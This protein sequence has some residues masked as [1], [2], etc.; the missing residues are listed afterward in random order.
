MSQ[1]ISYKS[2]FEVKV[3]HHYFLNKG[4]QAWDAMSQLEKVRQEEKFDVREILDI[5]PTADCNKLLN[6][7]KCIFRNTSSGFIIGIKAFADVANAGKFKPLISLSDN[8]TFRFVVKLKDYNFLNYTALTLQNSRNKL[9]ALNN[10]I[11]NTSYHFPSL[12]SIP[13][14][15][16]IGKTYMPGDMLSDNS[17]NQS[18]LFTALVKT[19]VNPVGSDDWLTEDGN[20][21]TP[22]NYV[23]INDNYPVA[24]GFFTYTMT[25]KDSY[26][27]AKIK[28][29]SGFTINP[30]MEVLQGDFYKLQIDML[31]YPEGI[32]SIHIDS[33][34]PAYHD[35][36]TFY[37]LQSSDIP[38]ALVEVKV[39]SKQT[40]FDLTNQGDLLS[41]VFEIRF[42]NR[43]THWR[44]VGKFFNTP[45][46]PDNPLPLTRYGNIEV[47]KP[48]D[49]ENDEAI[50]L[51]NPSA[52]LI[53]AEA[54]INTNETKFY[55]EIHIN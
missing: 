49:L 6:A 45:F 43:R 51:P 53:K 19:T 38:F 1:S 5:T 46:I 40:A 50:M 48:P 4:E 3:R 12:S 52:S 26:P 29:A 24:N 44:Y 47:M 39:K 36:V 30:K 8:E 37:L 22:I 23:N 41:P 54:L 11:S 42:R 27:I 20:A 2:L 10:S 31:K 9:F 33:D 35:D 28:D 7:H 14:V 15:F 25:E 55:S 16:E 32:Y 21:N 13:P 18:K 34:N 17:V